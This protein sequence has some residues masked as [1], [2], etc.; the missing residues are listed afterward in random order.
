[1]LNEY[2]QN[3]GFKGY[4]S[5]YGIVNAIKRGL[6]LANPF[7][8]VPDYETKKL[9]WQKQ[10][11]Q[12]IRKYLRY[13]DTAP[14]G[15]RYGESA[16]ENPIWIYWHS[17]MEN[18]PEIVQRCY[19]SVR[20]YAQ[21][22]VVLLTEK[23]LSDYLVFPEYVEEKKRN[24]QIPLA[25]YTDLMRFALL[26]HYGGTWIDATILLTGPIPE[27]ITNSDFFAFRNALGLLENPVL[28]PAWFMHAAKENKTITQVRNVAFAYWMKE[29]HVIEY[30]L[31]NLILTEVIKD[32][33]TAGNRI[34]YMDSEYSER[35]I[36]MIGEPYTH[37]DADWIKRLTPIH[38]LTYKLDPEV[39]QDNT[40]YRHIIEG[41]F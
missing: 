10:A 34:P 28:F 32:D 14:V 23:N 5:R 12:K 6:F 21:Q 27:Q 29:Q 30:L 1:M 36:R 19:E 2:Y 4:F 26:A 20:K 35:L 15:F 16:P 8:L 18:A 41:D 7:H 40:I 24:G 39:D 31:P 17:G 37:E 13:K 33:E 3:I 25:G 22:P 11:S 38:K 9:L